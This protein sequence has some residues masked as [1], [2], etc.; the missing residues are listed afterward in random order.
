MGSGSDRK[1]QRSI[2]KAKILLLLSL[3]LCAPATMARTAGPIKMVRVAVVC[4]GKDE[5]T[6]GRA[7]CFN[8]KEKIRASSGFQLIEQLNIYGTLTVHILHLSTK[9]TLD[10]VLSVAVTTGPSQMMLDL[11][12]NLWGSDRI[13]DAVNSILADLDDDDDRLRK[14]ISN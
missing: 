12:V 7:I 9:P 14:L 4:E 1:K 2:M 13:K 10:S 8:L 5:D 6:V 3:F 11:S